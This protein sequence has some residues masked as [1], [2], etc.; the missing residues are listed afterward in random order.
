MQRHNQHGDAIDAAFDDRLKKCLPAFRAKQALFQKEVEGFSRWHYDLTTCTLTFS[1]ETQSKLCT[2]VP[3]ATYVR[4]ANQWVWAWA[5][6]SLPQYARDRSGRLRDLYSAT[7]YKIF[8]DPGFR[9]PETDLEELCAL[10]VEFL[11]S[12]AVF[13][14]ESDVTKLFLAVRTAP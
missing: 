9:V 3:I 8:D 10:A 7:Q 11:G 2:F 13:T 1:N 14:A 6:E 5:N 12:D 4:E